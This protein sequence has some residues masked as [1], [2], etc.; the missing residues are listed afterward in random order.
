MLLLLKTSYSVLYRSKSESGHLVLDS[1]LSPVELGVET[2][3][4]VE[5]SELSRAGDDAL[6]SG[7]LDI[8]RNA[9]LAALEA[10]PRQRELVLLIAEIDLLM[11][12]TESA[13]GLVSESVPILTAGTIGARLL[14][15]NHELEAAGELLAQAARDERYSPLSAMMLLAR[16]EFEV[17]GVERRLVLDA[18]VA[19]SPNLIR[20]RWSRLEARA[21]FGDLAGAMAD[22]QHLEAASTGRRLR[23]EVCKRAAEVLLRQGFEQESGQLFQRALRY[24][25]EDVGA[26]VGLARSLCATG[27]GLRAIP[28]LERAIQM[29]ESGGGASGDCSRRVGETD[30]NEA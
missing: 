29:A 24:V 28:L 2:T 13:M 1:S 7:E 27:E 12:R 15:A 9:Y 19:A 26:M 23:H 22:A 25:P 8:A 3:R 14:L 21:E 16:A 5:L 10:A 30:C 11:G 17:N 6:A 20:A 18:A 4:V